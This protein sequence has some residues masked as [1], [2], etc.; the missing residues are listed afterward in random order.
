MVYI[1]FKRVPSHTI[2]M[3]KGMLRAFTLG[4]AFKLPPPTQTE[5]QWIDDAYL[6]AASFA[7]LVLLF[8]SPFPMYVYRHIMWAYDVVFSTFYILFPKLSNRLFTKSFLEKFETIPKSASK[9]QK[10]LGLVLVMGAQN[11]GCHL[12]YYRM[13]DKINRKMKLQHNITVVWEV[14]RWVS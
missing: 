14:N 5:H 6:F 10:V 13:M 12:T 2:N 7:L 11:E 4:K 8:L 1:I 3:L 9:S